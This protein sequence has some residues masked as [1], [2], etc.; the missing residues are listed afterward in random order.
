MQISKKKVFLQFFFSVLKFRLYF[1]HFEEKVTL[2]ADVFLNLQ[3][4]KNVVI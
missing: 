3:T 2:T 1:K 4:P